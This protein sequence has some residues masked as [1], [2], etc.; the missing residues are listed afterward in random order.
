VQ[1]VGSAEQLLLLLFSPFSVCRTVALVSP[2][3]QNEHY[4]RASLRKIKWKLNNTCLVVKIMLQPS[5]DGPN[6]RA[7]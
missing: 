5:K 4:Y 6:F 1:E 3:H 2:Y 7:L